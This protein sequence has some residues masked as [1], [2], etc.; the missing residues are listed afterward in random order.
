MLTF[1]QPQNCYKVW[2]QLELDQLAWAY[3]TS[4]CHGN[5][6]PS[7]SQQGR[8]KTEGSK[9]KK[10]KSEAVLPSQRFWE[11]SPK[12]IKNQA[13]RKQST[14]VCAQESGWGGTGQVNAG[15]KSCGCTSLLSFSLTSLFL[16]AL[17]L[18]S[19]RPSPWQALSEMAGQ[20]ISLD[21]R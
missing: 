17:K 15:Q 6:P 5:K 1:S 16:R 7:L 10:Q 12:Q 8:R 14:V 19:C 13:L 11:E 4:S 21:S 9:R 3:P 18:P 2:T 20:L